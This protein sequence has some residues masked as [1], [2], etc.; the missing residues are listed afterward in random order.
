MAK[1]KSSKS[2]S[3]KAK[4][5]AKKA[6]KK[7]VSKPTSRKPTKKKASAAASRAAA[8]RAPSALGSALRARRSV[9]F[10]ATASGLTFSKGDPVRVV[11]DPTGAL[12]VPFNAFFWER[13]DSQFSKVKTAVNNNLTIRVR[14]S[15]LQHRP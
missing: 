8:G 1:K 13:V 7:T 5:P 10:S 3:K 6:K 4:K 12:N 15:C 2:P 11:C 14:S 9:S